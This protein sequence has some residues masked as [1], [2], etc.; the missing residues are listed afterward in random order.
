MEHSIGLTIRTLSNLLK[1]RMFETHPSPGGPPPTKMHA[2]IIDF[3]YQNRES[4]IFQRDLEAHFSIRRSTASGLLRL[5][6]E[7]G[8]VYRESVAEDARLKRVALTDSAV[9]IHE[10][11]REQI[12]E[13]EALM[14]RG[15]PARD[16]QIFFD[17]AE[18]I[19]QN[20]S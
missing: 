6:E 3:L 10:K 18:K 17:V 11:I 13:T 7:R 4:I 12:A 14:A 16:L 19:K 2:E 9:A 20:L 5:M 15:I 8:I 1:R